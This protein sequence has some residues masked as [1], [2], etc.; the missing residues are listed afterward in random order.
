METS[1]TTINGNTLTNSFTETNYDSDGNLTSH[2]ETTDVSNTAEKSTQGSSRTWD[3]DG[4]LI[5]RSSSAE[6]SSGN[7]SKTTVDF[8]SDGSYT[9][10]TENRDQNANETTVKDT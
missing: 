3:G 5:P 4:N 2:T 8:N 10:T 7:S 6:D 9:I 1:Q